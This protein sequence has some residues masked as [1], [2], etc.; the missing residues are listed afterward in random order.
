MIQ[1][2]EDSSLIAAGSFT[3]VFVMEFRTTSR[4]AV[5]PKAQKPMIT[6]GAARGV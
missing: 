5:L 2:T 1:D 3:A 6:T 4:Q